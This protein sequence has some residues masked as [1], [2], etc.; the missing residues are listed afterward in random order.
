MKRVPHRHQGKGGLELVEE[1]VHL[2]RTAPSG[3]LASYY[4]GSLPFV[5]GLLYFWAE[6]SRNPFAYEHLAAASL[7]LAA[8]FL[9]MKFWQAVFA[10]HLRAA[11][12]IAPAAA[13]NFGRCCRVFLAQSAFQP[14]GLLLLPLALIPALPFAWA[15]AF[16]QNLTALDDGEAPQIRGLVRKATRQ[17][18]LWP[19]QN[20][21]VLLI[22]F[23]FGIAGFLNWTFISVASPSLIKMLFGVETVF[24]RSGLGLLNTTF[25]AAMFGLTYLCMDPIAKT[26]Y[27]LRCFYG[28]SLESGEDLKV[29]L[30]HHAAANHSLAV[31][32]VM[33]FALPLV[34]SL[35]SVSAAEPL[36]AKTQV[37]TERSRSL[38]GT[39]SSEALRS[40]SS[41][42]SPA[43]LDR[44]IED[45]IHQRKYAWRM[46]RERVVKPDA[47]KRG[48]VGRFFDHAR[49]PLRNTIEW[50][51]ELLRKL[52][53]RQRTPGGGSSGYDW[54][55]LLQILLYALVAAAVIALD[56]QL[57]R[58]KVKQSSRR[59]ISPTKTSARTNYRK[60]D[61]RNWPANFS[62]E[63]NC[64]WRCGPFTS[65][66]S[67]TWLNEI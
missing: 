50:L 8:L 58:F 55:M 22:L 15:Y 36:H 35:P 33:L 48:I 43:D 67:P 54:L 5:L 4:L 3:A 39:P 47:A 21:V 29:E 20:H 12:S 66:A 45:V 17:A 6:M 42:V 24:S 26:V 56:G 46:P 28:E 44:A 9:W 64:A 25:F 13:W 23:A 14:W 52:F 10:Q 7:A 57:R 62:N 63:A 53:A 40:V 32:V 37:L 11:I 38:T 51:G 59:P 61:G 34:A 2:L 16:F 49:K 1:A 19:R 30:K 65:P 41:A 18:A 31:A 60:T 27:V